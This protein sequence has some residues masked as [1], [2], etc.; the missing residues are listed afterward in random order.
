MLYS[1]F[2]ISHITGTVL[3]CREKTSDEKHK[4]FSVTSLG[5]QLIKVSQVSATI[6]LC[7]HV[8]PPLNNGVLKKSQSLNKNIWNQNISVHKKTLKENKLIHLRN[9][10]HVFENQVTDVQTSFQQLSASRWMDSARL[11]QTSSCLKAP[12]PAVQCLH[13]AFLLSTVKNIWRIV[14]LL[15]SWWIYINYPHA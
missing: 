10:I 4:V 6:L 3:F 13:S 8:K 2:Y 1:W 14:S 5:F 12:L 11:F 7:L 15:N 9:P